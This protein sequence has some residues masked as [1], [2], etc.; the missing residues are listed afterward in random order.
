MNKKQAESD[1][2]PESYLGNCRIQ[3]LEK[4]CI[5]CGKQ[6]PPRRA[7]QMYCKPCDEEIYTH[8]M[9]EE[10]SRIANRESQD[11]DYRRKRRR[12][13]PNNKWKYEHGWE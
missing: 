3:D 13:H 12:Y 6:L 9:R 5:M 11:S 7:R 8:M 10:A 1:L 4:V 2:M